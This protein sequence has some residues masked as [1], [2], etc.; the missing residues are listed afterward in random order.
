MYS[1]ALIMENKW[2][3]ARYGMN[4]KMIDFGKQIEVPAR[5]LMLEYLEFVDDVVDELDSGKRSSTCTRSWRW[6]P[7]R[8]VSSACLRRPET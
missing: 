3:A 8:T 1:R 7:A 6:A 5:E 4:G 2:R